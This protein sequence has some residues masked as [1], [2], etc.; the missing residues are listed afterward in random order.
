MY[1]YIYIYIY[2]YLYIYTNIHTH[3]HIY[4][5]IYTRICIHT[6]SAMAAVQ[7]LSAGFDYLNQ[8]SASR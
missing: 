8:L 4:T 2:I 1:I 5:N 6:D 3:T 7:H